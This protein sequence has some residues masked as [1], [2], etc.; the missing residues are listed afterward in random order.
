MGLVDR[1]RP[2]RSTPGATSGAV[3]A[4]AG[5]VEGHHPVAAA[6]RA[7]AAVLHRLSGTCPHCHKPQQVESATTWVTT[8]CSYCSAPVTLHA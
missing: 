1:I 6:E 7:A 4:P 5:P 2:H 8:P 3:P